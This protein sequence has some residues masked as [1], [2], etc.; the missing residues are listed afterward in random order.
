MDKEQKAVIDVTSKMDGTKSRTIEQEIELYC[1]WEIEEGKKEVNLKTKS[2]I[3]RMWTALGA[4]KDDVIV[5]IGDF[6][7]MGSKEAEKLAEQTEGWTTWIGEETTL[8]W[9]DGK[10]LVELTCSRGCWSMEYKGKTFWEAKDGGY[11]IKVGK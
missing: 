9:K 10:F 1:S 6:D 3:E 8:I 11:W 4:K 2:L 5:E 7:R